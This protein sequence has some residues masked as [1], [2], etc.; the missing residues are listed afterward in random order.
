MG[1]KFIG[2]MLSGLVDQPVK[3]I[4]ALNG[5]VDEHSQT[6]LWLTNYGKHHIRTA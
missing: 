4:L 6:A 5:L 2:G 3:P 1:L